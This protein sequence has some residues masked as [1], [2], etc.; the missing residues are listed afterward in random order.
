MGFHT[1]NCKAYH[2]E[3]WKAFYCGKDLYPMAYAWFSVDGAYDIGIHSDEFNIYESSKFEIAKLSSSKWYTK[4][5]DCSQC[6][7]SKVGLSSLCKT[8][9][10]FR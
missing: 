6:I 8:E 5:S 7:Y 3:W 2:I 10:L 4:N 1:E 9:S